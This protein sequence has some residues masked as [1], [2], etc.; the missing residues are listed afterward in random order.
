MSGS[1]PIRSESRTPPDMAQLLTIME[2]LRQHN[3]SLQLIVHTL[4]QT[5]NTKEDDKKKDLFDPQPL[6][7]AIWSDQLP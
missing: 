3:Q 6:S 7:E 2:N 5:Q 1:S 4:Q